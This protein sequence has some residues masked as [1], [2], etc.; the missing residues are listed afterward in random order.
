[1]ESS[2]Q[3]LLGKGH[4]GLSGDGGAAT[5][6]QIG[7]ANGLALDKTGNLYIVDLTGQR[8]RMVSA[9]DGTI[10][11]VA[12]TVALVPGQMPVT[13]GNGILATEAQLQHADGRGRRR[14]R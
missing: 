11:T 12:G 3:R 13:T 2:P 4:L 9:A 5:D 1:M 14:R 6:A 10:T 8:I 7:R